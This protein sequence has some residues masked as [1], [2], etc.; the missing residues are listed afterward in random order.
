[1]QKK[2]A[3]ICADFSI[4]RFLRAM[5]H[6]VTPIPKDERLLDLLRFNTVSLEESVDGGFAATET[7]IQIHSFLGTTLLQDVLA[8]TF[9][10]FLIEDRA[11]L[12]LCLFENRE[13]ISIE[14]FGPFVAVIACSITAGEDM[15][16]CGTHLRARNGRKNLYL[17][18]GIVAETANG[19]NRAQFVILHK[20]L[21]QSMPSHVEISETELAHTSIGSQVRLRSVHLI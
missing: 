10:C 19:L 4:Y 7:Y 3:L 8:E 11:V 17:L 16:E 5:D 9:R 6:I 18:H 15:R 12:G 21:L 20:R 14:E 2:S 1:M 13:R